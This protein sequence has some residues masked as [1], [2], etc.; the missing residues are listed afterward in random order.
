LLYPDISCFL[1]NLSADDTNL[2]TVKNPEPKARS[3]DRWLTFAIGLSLALV[4]WAVF[5]QTIRYGFINYDD[6]LYVYEN[7]VVTR[8]LD[9]GQIAWTFTHSGIDQ[10][11]PVTD[12]SHMLD[13]QFYGPDAGGHHLTNVLLHIAT[14]ILLFLTLQKMTRTTWRSAFVAAVFALHPLRV[15]SVA[16]I[17]ERKDVLSGLFFMLTLLL[18]LRYLQKQPS[19]GA[20]G[21]ATGTMAVI[22]P[23][24]WS[25]DYYLALAF[26][27]LGLLSKGMVVTLPFVLLL[28][29]YWPLNRL[30]SSGSDAPGARFRTWLRLF[31]EKVP[32]FLLSAGTCVVTVLSQPHVV[33]SVHGFTF[34]WRLGNAAMAYVDYLGHMLYPVGLA[35]LYTR[36]EEHLPVWRVAFSLALLSII[37]VGVFWGRRKHPYL[38][39]GWLWYL[40][41]FMPVIDIMQTGDHARADRYTYLPQIGLIILVTWGVAEFCQAKRYPQTV[42]GAA[43]GLILL[44]LSVGAYIQT[45]YWKDSISIWTHTLARTPQSYVAHCNLGIALAGQGQWDEAVQHFNQALQIN[46]DDAKSMNNLGKVLT[47]QGKLD[48]A[49]QRFNQALQINPDDVKTLN[50]LAVALAGEGKRDI[51]IQDLEQV[52]KLKPDYADACF[53]LGNVLAA[54]G[55]LDG[56]VQSYQQALQI[57]PDFPE[58]HCNLGLALA[59][60]R[61][62]DAAVQQYE[63]AIQL[64]PQYA[65]AL[66]DL[67]GA[68]AAQGNLDEAAKYYSQVLQLK[69][70][71]P[72]ALDNLGVALARQRKFDD[73]IRYFQRAL[74]INPNDAST[75]NNLGIALSNEGKLGE[76]A[77]SF[78][79]AL[80]LARAQGNIPLENAINTRL[81]TITQKLH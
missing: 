21:T 60:Q 32:F 34:L 23:R 6:D 62:L 15:E 73:A 41:M 77:Q 39:V 44:G 54:G 78:Q 5:G 72:A 27:A 74:Q 45:T 69:P 46:P 50:N 17:A 68:F 19:V 75:Y 64:K 59:R 40:G 55:D 47:A 43:A 8:G 65:D 1:K 81:N 10:W 63:L 13:W 71:D 67:G 25:A 57:N 56:A 9:L 4:V 37:S 49:V 7:P 30:S 61:N 35:L 2:K 36:P 48:D 29:D 51:A 20:P 31:L 14:A 66:A 3:F 80:Y 12:T 24:R 33:S 70:N 42:I 76:A 18:W 38:L 16:W 28:L 26:F 79:Q 58:A 11:Y 53:N 22:D 52:L